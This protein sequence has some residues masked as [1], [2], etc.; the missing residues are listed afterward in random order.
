MPS[1]ATRTRAESDHV[2]SRRRIL[3]VTGTVAGGGASTA[4]FGVGSVRA[5]QTLEFGEV[6]V[7]SSEVQTISQP[8]PRG[9]PLRVTAIDITGADADQ[10]SVVRGDAPFT[11]QPGEAQTVA[12]RFAPTSAGEKSATVQV[13][14]AGQSQTAGQLTGTG[15]DEAADETT[16]ESTDESESDGDESSTEETTDT[17][18]DEAG[19]GD[20]DA[21]A[22]DSS[23]T[24]ESSQVDD[25]DEDPPFT[26][27]LDL[28]GDGTVDY[29]DILAL[30]R[31]LS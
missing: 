21:A 31:A 15:V 9:Q 18:T 27:V 17:A 25:S 7:G 19:S 6:P 30:I 3:Q 23:D 10:F 14:V 24:E 20:S 2:I 29:R 26:L 4:L 22:E 1:S 12:I 11:L 16:D 8:N 13:E 5:Q 28:N